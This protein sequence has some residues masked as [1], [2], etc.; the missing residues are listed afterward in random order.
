MKKAIVLLLLFFVSFAH[1]QKISVKKSQLFKD[2][3]KHTEL[4]YSEEDGQGG[5][6]TLRKYYAGILRMPKGYYIEHFD[7]NLKLLS[8]TEVDIDRSFIDGLLVKDGKVH[9][10]EKKMGKESFAVN[11]LTSDL[12][13]L[14]FKSSE[15]FNLDKDDIKKYFGVVIGLFFINNGVSQM[16]GDMMGQL[17]FSKNKKFM[18]FNF[19]IKDKENEVHR[20]FVYDDNFNQVFQREFKRDIKDKYFDYEDVSVDDEDGSVYFLGKVYE[21]DSRRSKKKGKA[22]YHYELFKLNDEGQKQVSFNT[23]DHFVSSL[24]SLKSGDILS[25]VG[26][27][28]D[29]NDN[30]YKGIVRYDIDPNNLSVTKS[31]FQPFTEQFILDKYGKKKEK[32][33][34]FLRYRGLFMLEGSGDIVFNAEEFFITSHYNMNTGNTYTYYHY[35]DI[36]S[37]RINADGKLLWARNI[38]KKQTT[39]NPMFNSESYTS[40]VVND[41]VYIFLNG[42]TKVKKIKN[43][44]IQFKDAKAKNYNLYAIE[45]GMDGNFEYEI[46]QTNKQ[47]EVPL[48]V[49]DGILLNNGSEVIFFGRRKKEKQILKLTL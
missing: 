15:L 46:I 14:D 39:S 13:K 30:R 29:R 24:T 23:Q 33:L 4:V 40:T 45:I 2:K 35:N 26:F 21:G 19:D 6:I 42:S 34:K 48:Y 32:E 11:I 47:L 12:G 43:D 17:T 20:I 5:V 3:K 44:R 36:I 22:N 25:C 9:L 41:K 37:A 28:S 49:S 10:F 16:D 38:N 18:A 8:E 7:S 1:S 27:Y 31:S